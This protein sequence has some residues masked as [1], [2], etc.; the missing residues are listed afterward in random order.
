[1]SKGTRILSATVRAAVCAAGMAAALAGGWA[2]CPALA[3]DAAQGTAAQAAATATDGQEAALSAYDVDRLCR[4]ALSAG[5]KDVSVGEGEHLSVTVKDG[6]VWVYEAGPSA[7]EGA[8]TV[9]RSLMDG[10]YTATSGD[11]TLEVEVKGHKVTSA[12]ATSGEVSDTGKIVLDALSSGYE[13]ELGDDGDQCAKDVLAAFAQVTQAALAPASQGALRAAAL[14]EAL[15]G[16]SLEDGSSSADA[17]SH[18]GQVWVVDKQAWDEEVKGSYWEFND[19]TVFYDSDEGEAYLERKITEAR[20]LGLYKD[21]TYKINYT[22][23][24]G[25]YT[26]H[27]AAE[28]HWDRSGGGPAPQAP[29]PV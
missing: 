23:L 14:S 26:V 29:S 13:G 16:A 15:K 5:G 6:H 18:E 20:D 19:G 7:E 2:A 21:P 8:E 9:S 10:T 24:T 17:D 27:H 3:A 4:Q 1:M 28:G 25:T 11:M 12:K 22:V